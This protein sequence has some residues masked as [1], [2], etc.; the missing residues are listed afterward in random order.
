MVKS[1]KIKL[2]AFDWELINVTD[3]NSARASKSDHGSQ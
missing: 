1:P 3:Y 2:P